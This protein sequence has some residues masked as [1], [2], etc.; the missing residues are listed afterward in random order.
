MRSHRE[1]VERDAEQHAKHAATNTRAGFDEATVAELEAEHAAMEQQ[2]GKQSRLT[3]QGVQLSL[4]KRAEQGDFN[5]YSIA[6][7]S[8]FPTSLTRMPIFLPIQ[9]KK[10]QAKLNEENALEFETGWGKGK[11]WGASLTT[12]D[13]DTLLA[14]FHLRQK[15]LFG[16]GTKMPIAVSGIKI[17]DDQ[18]DD[19]EVHV[20]VTTITEI[21]EY[22][23]CKPGGRGFKKRLAS[24]KRLDSA[25]LQF[26]RLSDRAGGL[27]AGFSV[28]LI[29]VVWEAYEESSTLY[30]QFPPLMVTWLKESFTYIDMKIRKQLRGDT[31]KAIHKFLSGQQRFNIGLEALKTVTGSAMPKAKFKM[32]VVKT[33][34]ALVALNWC[35][36]ELRGTGR[37]KPF[38]LTGR[39]LKAKEHAEETTD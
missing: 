7:S 24:I 33:L 37:K 29:D 31:A 26:E 23:G 5:L 11:K 30:V 10:A 8:E 34:D 38:V 25:L 6:V 4:L 22:L 32:E 28:K 27:N 14:L 39:R 36:Y 13:E 9:R 20:L 3:P 16:K 19:V 2:T 17:R 21:E 12:Y 35:E 15:A 1:L 18:V